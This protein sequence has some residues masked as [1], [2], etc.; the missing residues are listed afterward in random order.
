MIRSVDMS[1]KLMKVICSLASPRT[2]VGERVHVHD[3][4]AVML[5][6]NTQRLARLVSIVACILNV[7]PQ[8]VAAGEEI[9]FCATGV[10]ELGSFS[11][12]VQQ[13]RQSKRYP[14]AA[15]DDLIA[16]ERRG[17]PD[18]F[19]SQIIMKDEQS[20]SGDYDL[21]LFHGHRDP[22]TRYKSLTAWRCEHDDYPVAY[23]V[24]F[25]V[26]EIRDVAIFVAREN[27]VVNVISLKDVD[28]N[29][30]KHLKVIDSRTQSVL[31]EDIGT[32]CIPRVFYGRW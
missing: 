4:I 17:G 31:C 5:V 19:S 14:S 18:F 10:I 1:F 15:I 25:R 27:G 23:F 13:L 26:T 20:S 29:L 6:S 21:S 8:S 7:V 30:N 28:P 32:G 9:H 22:H 24:G 12:H 16:K 2:T 3:S 11:E